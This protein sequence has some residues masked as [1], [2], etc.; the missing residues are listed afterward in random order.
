MDGT[1]FKMLIAA[2]KIQSRIR[3][4]GKQIT[5]DYQ[6]KELTAVGVLK[7]AFI[8]MAD[9]V[10][11]IDLTVYCEFMRISSYGD[12]KV[13]SGNVRVVNDIA[14]DKVKGK[15]LLL[16]E[17]IIDTGNS[18][19][20]LQD[21]L[22]KYEPASIKVCGLLLKEA[23]LQHPVK[24]AYIGFKI[25]PVFVIGYGLDYAEKFRN[26]PDILVHKD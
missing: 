14:S 16:V 3:E 9:L 11:A 18:I 26:L 13:S 23:K 19:V 2:K 24:I 1:D 6:G 22:K 25:E 15:H 12:E 20:F 21:Y 5:Q 17:D 10:R 4:M 7:G 8:F